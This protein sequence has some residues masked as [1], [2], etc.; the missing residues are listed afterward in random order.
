[1]MNKFLIVLV[2][3]ALAAATGPDQNKWKVMDLK[4]PTVK[5]E[6]DYVSKAIIKIFLYKNHTNLF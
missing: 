5:K 4:N 3:I 6:V 2:L 1:M